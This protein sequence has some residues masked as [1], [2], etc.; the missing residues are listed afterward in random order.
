[1][2][3]VWLNEGLTKLGSTVVEGAEEETEESDS[4]SESGYENELS[5]NFLDSDDSDNSTNDESEA[6]FFPEEGIF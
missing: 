4:V 6:D 3:L 2:K 5:I 1:M